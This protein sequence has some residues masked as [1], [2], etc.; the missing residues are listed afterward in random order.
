MTNARHQRSPIF[1]ITNE[2]RLDEIANGALLRGDPAG[3]PGFMFVSD[4]N[5]AT[6]SSSTGAFPPPPL[7]VLL[8]TP[9]FTR[10]SAANGALL[11]KTL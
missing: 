11:C 6:G 2:H 4:N 9:V 1:G 3:I 7:P 5:A 10:P 8:K